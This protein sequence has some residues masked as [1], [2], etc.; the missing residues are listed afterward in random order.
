MKL[1][2]LLIETL[3]NEAGQDSGHMELVSITLEDA[4]EFCE[5]LAFNVEKEIPNFDRNFKL[6][7]SL[8]SLGKTQRH[9]MPVIDDPQVK[10]FQQRL[11][12]GNLDI[13]KPFSATTTQT[14]PFPQG[15]SGFE[16]DDFLKRGLSDG[17]L[18]DDKI[19]V[20]IKQKSVKSL[21]PIQR[22]IYF[23]KAF[24]A[25]IKTGVQGTLKWLK[26]ETF[27]ITSD[28]N[29]IIDGHHRW[30]S[31]LLVDPN[32]YVNCLS[33]GLPIKDLLPLSIA[34]GDAIGNARNA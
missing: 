27:F 24:G 23:D 5:K 31:G 3:L 28:D 16:A 33:I 1:R 11:K 13:F 20:S 8:A 30:L 14:N 34:Y 26:A 6:A 25:T 9:D 29:F 32:I 7:Q 17:S 12:N 10:E 4:K 19:K 18:T 2:T 15:L 22:Q 21:K